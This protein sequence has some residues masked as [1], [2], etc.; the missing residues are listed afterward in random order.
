[1][2]KIHSILF[3]A[4][5]LFAASCQKEISNPEIDT[6]KGEVMTITATTDAETKTTLDG[7]ATLWAASDKISVFDSNKGANNRCF[8]INDDCDGLKTATFSYEGEF[9]MPQNGQTDPTVVALYPYQAEAY[10]D[11]FF[12]DHADITGI[13]IETEQTAV[14]GGFDADATFALA[15]GTLS[16]KDKLKFNNLYSL[17]KFTVLDAGVKKVTVTVEG[18]DAFVAGDAR[19]DLTINPSAEA[20]MPVFENPILSAKSSKTVTLSCEEGFEI[21]KTYYI[22]VAPTSYTGISVALDGTIVKTSDNAKTLEK[23]TVY[24][25][26][27]L[28]AV[29]AYG[30]A[31]SFQGWEPKNAIPMTIHENGWVVAKNIELYKDDEFKFVKDNAWTTSYG[32]KEI[33]VVEEDK[34]M[35]VQTDNGKNMKVSKNGKYNLYL[36]PGELKVKIECVKEYTDLTVDITI[37]NKANWNPLYI[38]L[39]AEGN[40]ITPAEGD[41][42]SDNVYAVKGDYIGCDLTCKFISGAKVSEKMNVAITKTGATVTLEEKII[43][44]QVKLNTDN[45]KKWWG[46]TMKI[47]AWNTGTSFDTSWPGTNMTSEGNYTW[48]IIV[49]SELIGKKINYLV[50]NGNGWQSNDATVTISENGNTVTGSS[51][52]IN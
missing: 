27:E 34:E 45:A 8:E 9:I 38:Y 51:I 13:N 14:E 1:M 25:L 23:N 44:L 36:N 10:C 16:T 4:T 20:G 42:V 32:P 41:L 50:H 33:T 3:A 12:S 39:E 47:H 21:G 6:P 5:A 52:G 29:S 26:G 18:D 48:S 17:L 43:K 15:L 22:A 19:I 31:G 30:I 35:A 40:P 11:F 2:K 28:T 49:P 37:D 46:D 7:M 24:N